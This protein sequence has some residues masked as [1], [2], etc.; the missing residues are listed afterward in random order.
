M[1]RRDNQE[2]SRVEKK[3]YLRDELGA[4]EELRSLGSDGLAS[5]HCLL[6]IKT[7]PLLKGPVTLLIVFEL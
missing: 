4:V 3:G 1:Q 2:D 7:W 6:T 5:I